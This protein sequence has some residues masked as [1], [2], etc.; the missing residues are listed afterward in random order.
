MALKDSDYAEISRLQEITGLEHRV[1]VVRAGLQLLK[2]T[3]EDDPSSLKIVTKRS[4]PA[5]DLVERFFDVS[6]ETDEVFP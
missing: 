2:E 5:K 3:L 4:V 1:D 6:G